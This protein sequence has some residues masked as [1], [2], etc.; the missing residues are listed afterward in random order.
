MPVAVTSIMADHD[1][2]AD[3][4]LVQQTLWAGE[5][6]AA[7]R[8]LARFVGHFTRRA[9]REERVLRDLEGL[10][11]GII[12]RVR[13]EHNRLYGLVGMLV[14]ALASK[15]DRRGLDAIEMLRS[16]LVI[17]VAKEASFVEL[18]PHS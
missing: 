16:V 5:H 12:R 18:G 4:E 11:D 7:R 15:N 10:P 13:R 6:A 9:L 14:T 1:L 8:C 2:D 3:L 17:H